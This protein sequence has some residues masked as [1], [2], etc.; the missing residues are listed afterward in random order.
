MLPGKIH[1]KGESDHHHMFFYG[2]KSSMVVTSNWELYAL[3]C[4]R[5][6]EKNTIAMNCE[7]I[8]EKQEG[9]FNHIKLGKDH[10]LLGVFEGEEMHFVGTNKGYIYRFNRKTK[11]LTEAIKFGSKT[12]VFKEITFKD[13]GSEVIVSL[14]TESKKIYM[15][16]ISLYNEFTAGQITDNALTKYEDKKSS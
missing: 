3:R 6:L 1:I 11:L 5:S 7:K 9:K 14:L 13:Y 4:L 8:T 2:H 12:D 10:N 16:K 15:G